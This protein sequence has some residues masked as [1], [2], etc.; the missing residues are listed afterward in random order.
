MR[1]RVLGYSDAGIRGSFVLCVSC[2]ELASRSIQR[3]PR[4]CLFLAIAF[5]QAIQAA[6][7]AAYF[8]RNTQPLDYAGPGREL[9]EPENLQEVRIGYYGPGDPQ[10]RLAGDL[11]CA[12]LLAI[13]EANGQGGYRGKPFRLVPRWSE[14][15][16]SGGAA[17]VTEM[18]YTDQVWAIVGGV[19]SASTHLAEQVTTK[20]RLPLVSAASSD[21]TANSAVV[22][23]FFSLLPGDQLQAPVLVEELAGQ[24]G[25]EPFVVI[26]GEDHDWRS[27][28]A[29][30][31]RELAKRGLTPQ[32]QFTYRPL[33]EDCAE[34]VRRTLDAR[35]AAVVLIAD[36]AGSARLVRDL[37]AGGF[38]G[39]VFGGPSMGRRQFL[40]EAG[41]AAEGAVFPCLVE[42]G[43][44]W[45]E[46]EEAFRKRFQ[47]VPDYAA[48]A[49]YDAVSLLVAAIRQ[50][51]LNRARIDD[52]L[53]ELSPWLG[54]AG[55]VSWDTLGG[56]TRPPRLARITSGRIYA[57]AAAQSVSRHSQGREPVE[58]ISPGNP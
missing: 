42:P 8:D 54:A 38:Q 7:P 37:R 24:V 39:M 53:R 16:W 46:L 35:P 52:S 23:W 32:F 10:H 17:A 28:H 56:N 30:L 43:E 1:G 44:R 26:V 9:P 20:A 57:P 47:R 33:D 25:A 14:N 48:A 18:V 27:F 2:F 6:E 4:L 40:Q 29:Q 13:E 5:C 45:P 11:W 55:T 31:G 51:G 15:P 50:A 21:R 3:L 34:L 49:T 12:A 19:D 22:P 36:A 58:G 41:A